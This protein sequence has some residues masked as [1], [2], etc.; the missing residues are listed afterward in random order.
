MEWDHVTKAFWRAQREARPLSCPPRAH[1]QSIS[2]NVPLEACPKWYALNRTTLGLATPLSLV[3]YAKLGHHTKSKV[4]MN[5]CGRKTVVHVARRPIIRW[6]PPFPL[7]RGQPNWCRWVR[8]AA[9]HAMTGD[10][11]ADRQTCC[12]DCPRRLPVCL[13]VLLKAHIRGYVCRKRVVTRVQDTFR[14]LCL[15]LNHDPNKVDTY[16]YPTFA[17]QHRLCRPVWEQH[18]DW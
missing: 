16:Y 10:L 5:V 15:R 11:T 17:T 2:P 3:T 8:Q 18:M 6:T 14:V 13:T 9:R 4:K 1:T 12:S 7:E